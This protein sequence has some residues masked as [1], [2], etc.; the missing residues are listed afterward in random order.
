MTSDD[1]RLDKRLH[2]LGFLLLLSIFSLVSSLI[3]PVPSYTV[4]FP[5][6]PLPTLA[7]DHDE[8]YERETVYDGNETSGLMNERSMW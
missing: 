1:E 8:R 6:S 2:F 3:I 4:R 5:A 7:T